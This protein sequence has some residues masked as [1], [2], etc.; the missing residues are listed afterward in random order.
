MPSTTSAKTIEKIRMIFSTHGLPLQIV[1]DNGTA[2]TSKEFRQ[3]MEQNGIKDAS[4]APYHPSSNSLAEWAVQVQTF[5]R[6]IER[7]SDLPIQE[8]CPSFS[9]YTI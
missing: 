9:S 1:T 2:F 3:F 5:K 6:A 7:M 8:G 4:S